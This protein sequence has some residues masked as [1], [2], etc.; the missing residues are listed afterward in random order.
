MD[1]YILLNYLFIFVRLF[2]SNQFTG[3]IPP[4][5]G[6]IVKLKVL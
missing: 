2:D 5:V 3:P 6:S 4:E 1:K